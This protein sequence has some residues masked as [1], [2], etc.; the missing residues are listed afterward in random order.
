M[1]GAEQGLIVAVVVIALFAL[2]Q[3]LQRRR[4]K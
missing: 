2:S 1:S 4:R 3:Y